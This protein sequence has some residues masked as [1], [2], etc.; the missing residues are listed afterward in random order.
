[1]SHV[2]IRKDLTG[3]DLSFLPSGD[4]DDETLEL[5]HKRRCGNKD[6]DKKDRAKRFILQ[7]SRWR[8]HKLTYKISQYPSRRLLSEQEVNE[9]MEEA[10]KV[11]SDVADLEF[12]R[13]TDQE[14]HIVIEFSAGNHG[15]DD[16]FDGRG[17]R[18]LIQTVNYHLEFV[19]CKLQKL[20]NLTI[21]SLGGTLAHAFFPVFGG[22][23]HFD[24]DERWTVK[25]FK[26]VS[27]VQS[28][29]H[30]IGHSLGI[31]QDNIVFHTNCLNL[32]SLVQ[33]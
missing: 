19:K 24:R 13:V 11:W 18:N 4:L 23:V 26:G 9:A 15:D 17:E 1:M 12:E 27:L 7:G 33:L 2:S 25:S 28:A 8:T 30:E 16:P 6:V 29:A 21:P 22:D 32:H 14:A 5:M 31:R 10:F 3:P 20:E